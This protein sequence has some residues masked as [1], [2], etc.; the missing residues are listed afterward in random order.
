MRID[1]DRWIEQQVNFR[2]G[3]VEKIRYA[4]LP[5]HQHVSVGMST[6]SLLIASEHRFTSM[7]SFDQLCKFDSKQGF[8]VMP[9]T[10]GQLRGRRQVRF[11]NLVLS[12]GLNAPFLSNW[13]DAQGWNYEI[14]AP[15][16]DRL[17]IIQFSRRKVQRER[18][19]LFPL[20]REF[21][22]A[23]GKNIP[24][25]FDSLNFN[26]K[27]DRL[28]WRGRYTGT[29]S[30]WKTKIFWAESLVQK[31]FDIID[32]NLMDKYISIPRY[33]IMK[34]MS[35][36]SWADLG[37]TLK[38]NEQSIVDASKWKREF[39][40]PYVKSPLSIRDQIQNKFILAMSGNDYPSSLYWSLCSN[41]VVFL[42]ENEWETALDSGLEPWVHYVPI[43]LSREDIEGK[44]EYMISRP[45]L[46]IEI[47]ENAHQY[48]APF[49]NHDLRDAADYET[50]RNYH[51]LIIPIINLNNKWSF[52]R[53]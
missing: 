19:V 1:S 28:V 42:L 37:F 41:S 45:K 26:N 43:E 13:C 4:L 8:F 50:L 23:G 12:W 44:F 52:S 38:P 18:I 3:N 48:M 32:D 6:L 14:A 17:P 7:N 2:F 10:P 51:E 22:G 27:K 53:S 24:L 9:Q 25:N 35:S 36:S 34:I 30:D 20:N 5:K 16:L 21:M 33:T 31:D 47:I 46:C 29:L 15:D 11:A 40:L 49:L 39:L